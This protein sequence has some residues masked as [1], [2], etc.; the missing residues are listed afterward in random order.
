[1]TFDTGY[2]RIFNAPGIDV[3]AKSGTA[4]ATISRLH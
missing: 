1:M 3:W 4:D 2:E